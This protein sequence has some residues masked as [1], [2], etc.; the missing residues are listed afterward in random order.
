MAWFETLAAAIVTGSALGAVLAGFFAYRRGA[1]EKLLRAIVGDQEKRIKQLE[2]DRDDL[3]AERDKLAKRVETL[4]HERQLPLT[5][6][7]Q[8]VIQQNTA[9]LDAIKAL[10]TEM[11]RLADKFAQETAR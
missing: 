9:Q 8:L 7:T 11:A 3:A 10:T 5:E 4:E 2:T 6:L 1:S